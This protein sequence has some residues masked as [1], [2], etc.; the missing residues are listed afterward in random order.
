MRWVSALYR[1]VL[2]RSKLP[3]PRFLLPYSWLSVRPPSGSHP[4]HRKQKVSINNVIVSSQPRTYEFFFFLPILTLSSSPLSV[5]FQNKKEE[6]LPSPPTLHVFVF[7][8]I[9]WLSVNVTSKIFAIHRL[10]KQY[11][12]LNIIRILL[13]KLNV[14]HGTRIL[15]LLRYVT[16]DEFK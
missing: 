4:S 7:F 16:K 5:W 6:T 12:N 13:G 14:L 8:I 9:L 1:P 2:S 10:S 15:S 3:S 11:H